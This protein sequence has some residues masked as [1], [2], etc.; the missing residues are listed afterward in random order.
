VSTGNRFRSPCEPASKRS[1]VRRLCAH[2]RC[3]ADLAGVAA[4]LGAQTARAFVKGGIAGQPTSPPCIAVGQGA[5]RPR[6]ADRHRSPACRGSW[7]FEAYRGLPWCST[8]W[9]DG[10]WRDP[11]QKLARVLRRHRSARR[12][13]SSSPPP[14]GRRPIP[15]TQRLAD[16]AEPADLPTSTPGHE[17]TCLAR[18]AGS[19]PG[20]FV[21]DTFAQPICEPTMSC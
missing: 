4:R 9:T 13:A 2:R 15:A 19:G 6:A 3:P 11:G 1:A 17:S 10:K 8:T 12:D 18:R 14:S 21:G 7:M 5:A 16:A 20:C